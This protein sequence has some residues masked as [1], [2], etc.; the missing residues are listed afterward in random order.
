MLGTWS[1]PL[2]FRFAACLAAPEVTL[3]V[4][5]L[6]VLRSNIAIDGMSRLAWVS[7]VT[8]LFTIPHSIED[9]TYG[10][11][12]RFGLSVLA[13]ATGLG[14]VLAAQVWA[15]AALGWR[16]TL[17]RSLVLAIGLFW[18]IGALADHVPDLLTPDWRAGVPS[19]AL[20]VGIMVSQALVAALAGIEWRQDRSGGE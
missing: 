16:P 11:A 19:Q 6:K 7:S 18:V 9:F 14:I 2:A 15:T 4:P 8:F 17:A 1:A 5:R 20:V 10:I 12:Q 3:P 13:A